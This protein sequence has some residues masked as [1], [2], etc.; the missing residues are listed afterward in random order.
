M[1]PEHALEHEPEPQRGPAARGVQRVALPLVAAEPQVRERVARHQV[2]GLGRGRGALQPRRAQH[3]SLQGAVAQ[4]GLHVAH[5]AHH[6]GLPGRRRGLRGGDH[7]EHDDV[8]AGDGAAHHGV[9]AARV[10]E[11]PVGHVVPE[12]RVLVAREIRVEWLDVL[13][14]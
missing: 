14:R 11:G 6:V 5:A 8:G 13:G 10:R 1:L 9:E 12:M 4:V 3:A 2:H 7:G